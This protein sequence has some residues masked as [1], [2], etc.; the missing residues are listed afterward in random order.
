MAVGLR[1]RVVRDAGLLV[2]RSLFGRVIGYPVSILAARAL[3]PEAFGLL[4]LVNVIPG[5]AK[6]GGLGY[7][8]VAV[9]EVSR[10]RRTGQQPLIRGLAWPTPEHR[11]GWA[12]N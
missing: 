11:L 7:G 6:Y 4:Q 5:L 2:S 9:R 10:L 12:D 1:Q 8:A 3:G